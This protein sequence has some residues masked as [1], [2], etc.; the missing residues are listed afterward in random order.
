MPAQ[1][2]EAE[3]ASANKAGERDSLGSAEEVYATRASIDT[4]PSEILMRIISLTTRADVL[5]EWR[6]LRY[7]ASLQC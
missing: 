1:L 4:L 2:Y 5:S 3:D 7:E 6:Q